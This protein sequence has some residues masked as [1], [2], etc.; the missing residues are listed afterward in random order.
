MKRFKA[1]KNY[2]ALVMLI[3][4]VLFIAGCAG[5]DELAL[6]EAHDNVL[7]GACTAAGP[8]VTTSIPLNGATGVSTSSPAI[9]AFFDTQMDPATIVSTAVPEDPL[10]FVLYYM[11]EGVGTIVPGTVTYTYTL[12]VLNYAEFTPANHLSTD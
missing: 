9:T 8:Q 11:V 2:F 5:S 1:Q 3:M 12:G 6:L 10:T 4:G 7:P